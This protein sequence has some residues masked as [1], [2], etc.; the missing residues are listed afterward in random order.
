MILA[1]QR[2]NG[3][4]SRLVR[5]LLLAGDDAGILRIAWEQIAAGAQAL[6]VCAAVPGL[7]GEAERLSRLVAL[8]A[9]EMDVPLLI[10]SADPDALIA[11]LCACPR[12][13]IVN[14]VNL[15]D[16]R[17]GLD[18]ILPVAVEHG[19]GVIAQT[20]DGHGVAETADA[21]LRLAAELVRIL[22]EGYGLSAAS[23]LVD[24]VLLPLAR[25]PGS[26]REALAAVRRIKAELPGVRTVL[27]AGNLSYGLPSNRRPALSSVFLEQA[28][29]AGLDMA[30][31][32]PAQLA[33]LGRLAP[34][35]REAA[36]R[37][38]A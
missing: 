34:A 7:P 14:S 12:P 35:A 27:A 6:D 36:E 8:L 25:A 33:R 24:P 17:H 37:A 26:G 23:I 5:Q 15:I 9:R 13:A 2:L 31:V 1:G 21:K 16:R 10:D 4:G 19:A 22:T 11:A 28:E 30:I 3:S 32:D 38:L 18:R 20:I 29:Q